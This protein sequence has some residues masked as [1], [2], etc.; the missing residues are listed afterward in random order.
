MHETIGFFGGSFDPVHFGHINFAVETYERKKIDKILFCPAYVS[1]FKKGE[2]PVEGR[3]RLEMLRLALEEIPFCSISALELERKGVSY[4]IDTLKILQQQYPKGT[5]FRLLLAEDL[6]KDFYKWKD[7]EELATL[8]PPIIGMRQTAEEP[9]LSLFSLKLK[10]IIQESYCK[11]FN[12]DISSTRIRK[13]LRQDLY[14]GH[15]VP[16][17]V[18]DYIHKYRLY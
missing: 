11:I 12:M 7:A 9:D 2:N 1:P 5:R 8:A 15:L 3:H 14:C 17:K 10:K 4:T 16:A 18:L 13:R 6:A